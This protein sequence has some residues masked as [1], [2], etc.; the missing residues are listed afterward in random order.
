M[1]LILA[2][3][4]DRKQAAKLVALARGSLGADIVVTDSA[5]EALASMAKTVPDLVLISQLLSPKDDA[6]ITERLRQLDIAGVSV[7]TLVIPILGAP[8]RRPSLKQ[9]GLLARLRKVRANDTAPD[10]C[11]P[12]V[13]AAQIAE[14][15]ER[16]A[17]EREGQ[18]A[19]TVELVEETEPVED[20]EPVVEIEP[21]RAEA[22]V[23]EDVDLDEP[24]SDPPLILTAEPIDLQAFMREL[25]GTGTAD[26]VA[27]ELKATEPLE[28]PVWGAYA[29]PRLEG[30]AVADGGLAAD[31]EL[32]ADPEFAEFAAA[33]EDL[34]LDKDDVS[35]ELWMPL[36]P[37]CA[38]PPMESATVRTRAPMADSRSTPPQD[39]WGFFDPEQCGFSA[40][41]K[42]LATIP[43]PLQ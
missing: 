30:E 24:E 26:E 33:L 40:V 19:A 9:A 4:P 3:Q 37:D 22:A 43:D 2:V 28:P 12:D 38:W 29:W 7:P 13:F 36:Q 41:M 5:D 11:D 1:S 34:S 15:L 17:T 8:R 6:A 23:W 42:R 14:Y 32:A 10:G 31:L 39:Q 16:A 27:V 25:E 21:P 18:Q 35:E 20:L